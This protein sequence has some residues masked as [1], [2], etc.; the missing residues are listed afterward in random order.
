MLKQQKQY[1]GELGKTP[2]PSA[3]GGARG[4]DPVQHRVYASVLFCRCFAVMPLDTIYM[5]TVSKGR[6]SHIQTI[7]CRNRCHPDV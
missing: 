1:S 5:H 7:R 3:L 2:G 6:V 4:S